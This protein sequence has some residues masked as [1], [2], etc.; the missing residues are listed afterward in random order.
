M[1]HVSWQTKQFP[2]VGELIRRYHKPVLYDECRYEGNLPESWGNISGKDMT[3]R[4]WQVTTQG[5]FCTHGETFYPGTEIA[6]ENTATG[7]S[8]V[9]WWARGGRLHG[10]S[11]ERI[12]FLRKIVESLP[13]PLRPN[14]TGASALMGKSDEEAAVM[15]QQIPEGFRRFLS[16]LFAMEAAER[17][18][19]LMAEPEF[20]GQVGDN[21][22]FLFYKDTQCCAKTFIMLPE[23]A[24]YQ[25]DVIDT[26]NMTRDTV[27]TGASGRTEVDLPGRE[28]MAIL[29]IKE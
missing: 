6:K 20:A 7:E 2:R 24:S 23:T 11:P 3:S 22:A 9:V 5:G 29:A 27:Q 25:I 13:G 18:K 26:W 8:E 12:A 4:F 1:T 28:Y 16:N 14:E 17:D 10:E 15:L 19:F 21:E